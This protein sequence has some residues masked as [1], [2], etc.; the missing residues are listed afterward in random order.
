MHTAFVQLKKNAL[1]YPL[2]GS[3]GELGWCQ[4]LGG[5]SFRT[6][7]AGTR[8]G[9]GHQTLYLIPLFPPTPCLSSSCFSKVTAQGDLEVH[10]VILD[11]MGEKDPNLLSSFYLKISMHKSR[12]AVPAP[13]VGGRGRG[14]A[15]DG[16]PGPSNLSEEKPLCK[17]AL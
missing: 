5:G 4:W 10:H 13:V 1:L 17:R 14:G 7:V 3:A 15:C 2:T 12:N 6:E 11:H 9:L 16:V 8:L